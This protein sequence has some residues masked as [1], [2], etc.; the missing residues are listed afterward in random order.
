VNDV[1]SITAVP[2]SIEY[3]IDTAGFDAQVLVLAVNVNGDVTVAPFEGVTT[4]MSETCAA[5][6]VMFSSTSACA[7]WPQHLTCRTCT[8]A[9]A[10]TLALN[11]VGSI[12]AVPLSIEY[13]I[14]TA[15]TPA[16]VVV[17]ALTVNGEV[18]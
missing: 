17:L 7:F 14:E 9:A 4:V 16:H 2:L 15:G 18:T 12:T 6:T 5:N 1:G 10:V 8:P 11:D 3:P 13:P